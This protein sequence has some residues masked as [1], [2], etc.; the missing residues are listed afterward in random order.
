MIVATAGHI[1]HG[2]TALVRALTGIDADRL[3]EEKARG[4]TIDLGFAYSPLRDGT[5]TLGF[6]DVP[7][8]ERFVRNM[9]A[10]VSGIDFALLVIAADD[11][12]MP[13][14]LEHL[15]ILDLLRIGRGAVA[16]TKTDRASDERVAE[17]SSDIG[18]LLGSTALAHAPVFPVCNLTGEGVPALRTHLERAATGASLRAARGHFRLAV[19]RCFSLRG[20]GLV[21]TG[22]AFAGSVKVG[23]RLVV[24]PLGASVRVRGIH[25]ENRETHAAAAGQRCALN[26]AGAG[27]GKDLIARG[28]WVVAEEIHAPTR[29]LDV[30]IRLLSEAGILGPR[31]R[32]PVH[33]HLGATDITGR[34]ALLESDALQP[35]DSGFGQ[36]LLDRPIHALNGDRFVLRDQSAQL[37][38]GGGRVIDP[39]P[40][41]RGHRRPERLAMLEALAID[42]PGEAIT[43]ALDRAPS[44]IDLG[45]FARARNLTPAEQGSLW[46]KVPLMRIG[47]GAAERGI[48]TKSWTTART[49]ILEALAAWHARLPDQPGADS[50][51]LRR[52]VGAGWSKSLFAGIV[53]ELLNAGEIK[54]V[55]GMLSLP[56]H[57]A[58]MSA[59]DTALWSKVEPL[60]SAGGLRPPRVREIADVLKVAPDTIDKLLRRLAR[61]GFVQ[62]VAD[63]RFFPP[64]ALAELARMAEA[65]A[66]EGT[67]GTF[68]AAAYKDRTGIG[69][70]VAIELLEFFDRQGFTRRT[71]D[72]RRT[73]K[74]A[75]EAFPD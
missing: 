44:G 5:A 66:A 61:L 72:G 7:G 11:G 30:Q 24:S 67:D 22:S 23:D 49:L 74:P 37:T 71:G 17:V 45:L 69:R 47:E 46:R 68:T 63:N 57:T 31:D 4:M 2:K 18:R 16:L 14:T 54:R 75:A 70:N 10:G 3:P 29:R 28:D 26:L 41:E 35:G 64:A 53:A 1:D 38:I 20:A 58:S 42:D 62:P 25:A 33:L 32:R 9:L 51:R 59:G 73:V 12:P 56:G 34:L 36:L 40:P 13:Q 55:G 48:A 19:D 39:F 52:A 50:E 65:L 43:E 8:H 60:L 21:V 6:V 15:A 27:L